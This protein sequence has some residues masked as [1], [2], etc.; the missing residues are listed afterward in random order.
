M[1][2]WLH[3]CT[4]QDVPLV[5]GKC[6]SLGELNRV[7]QKVPPGFAITVNA[8]REFVTSSG[9]TGKID[10]SIEA[11]LRQHQG[12]AAYREANRVAEEI[13]LSTPLPVRIREA[14][15]ENYAA[16]SE[17]C[18]CDNVL[19]AV[20]SSTTMEDS[21]ETSFAGQHETYLNVS[22]PDDVIEKTL[23]CWASLFSAPALHY[24]TSR[25]IPH[26]ASMMAVAVQKM[27]NSRASGVLF[28]LDPITGDRNK[29]VIEGAWGLGE[30]VVSGH[31]T[32]DH[33]ALRKDNFEIV[34]EWIS[35]KQIEF[36]RDPNTGGTVERLVEA[37]RQAISCLNR[38]QLV[39]LARLAVELEMHYGRPQDIEWGIDADLA[40]PE[41]IMLLQSRPITMSGGQSLKSATV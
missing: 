16:L 22:G 38:D 8:Y 26:S 36:V 28:T 19:V 9:L 18:R 39:Q 11:V 6:A 33:F 30:G 15:L 23:R 20:R 40:F 34:E 37:E 7:G 17:K 1:I 29:V 21:V 2:R 41:N 32:P 12:S 27:V 25:Q 5:G 3:E 24:R 14:I 4:N 10:R 35:P 31:V 13:M